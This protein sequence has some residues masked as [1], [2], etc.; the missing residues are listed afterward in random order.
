MIRLRRTRRFSSMVVPVATGMGD[1]YENSE[2]GA[3]SHDGRALGMGWLARRRRT[4]P[5]N[6]FSFVTVKG[7][8]IFSSF[9]VP[10][11]HRGMG[12]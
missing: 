4:N 11:C 12:D 10:R 8:C 7:A 5:A 6:P 1:W 9:V 3:P 2:L